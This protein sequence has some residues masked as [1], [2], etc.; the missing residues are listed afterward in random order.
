[1]LKP[2]LLAIVFVLSLSIPSF[3]ASL[4]M[5]LVH[6]RTFDASMNPLA[7]G[8]PIQA[9]DIM[10]IDVRM[11]LL[12]AAVNEDFGNTSFSIGLSSGLSAV[13]L[14]GGKWM[15]PAAAESSG[16]YTDYPASAPSLQS[17]GQFDSNGSLP[18]G[19]QSHWLTNTDGGK[20]SNDL[21][22][23]IVA[24]FPSE[25][26]NRQYGEAVRP[27]A[28]YADQLGS[29][30]L[31]GRFLVQYD[32]SGTQQITLAPPLP[33]GQWWSTIPNNAN[34]TGQLVAQPSDNYFGATLSLPITPVPEPATLGMG[35]VGIALLVA[36][37]R[38][39]SMQ[40]FGRGSS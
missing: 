33:F 40:A 26:A 29:P 7:S 17:Y 19:I 5:S 8:S 18:S 4:S 22:A 37:R 28:G 2:L 35:I 13:D 30:T 15:S 36:S 3:A 12:G 31:L 32:G 27:G 34:G 23:I 9:G 1:M 20:D 14:G 38:A 24:M 39:R 6:S 21:Q 25:A 16:V 11:Q 10:L